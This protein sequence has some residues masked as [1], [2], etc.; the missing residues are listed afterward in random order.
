[1][2]LRVVV[3]LMAVILLGAFW[4]EYQARKIEL[5]QDEVKQLQGAADA[6]KRI[7]NADTSRGDD[8]DDLDWLC[9]RSP[10]SAGCAGRS[11]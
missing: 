6:Y 10:A 3:V 5:L 8:S 2:M 11:K 4:V 9:K 7:Q 1:M